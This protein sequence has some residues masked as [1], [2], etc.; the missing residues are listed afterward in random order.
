[1]QEA[2]RRTG[3]AAVRVRA[4][5]HAPGLD[6]AFVDE[7]AGVGRTA[8]EALVTAVEAWVAGPLE[9]VREVLTE[10]RPEHRFELTAQD[11]AG[12]EA[13]F[14]VYDGPLQLSGPEGAQRGLLAAFEE[15]PPFARVAEGGA[16]G[17]LTAGQAHWLKLYGARLG[18]APAVLECVLDGEDLPA[19]VAALGSVPWPPGEAHRTFRQ[20]CVLVPRR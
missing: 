12:G 4:T 3:F 14:A 11:G 8:A 9:L 15:H 17:V 20:Y 19:G 16:L 2:N 18:D 13:R 1:V 7:F 6:P 5:A 10:P